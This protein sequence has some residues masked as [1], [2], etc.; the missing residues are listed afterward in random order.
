MNKE[1]KKLISSKTIQA[2][3]E[4]KHNATRIFLKDFSSIGLSYTLAM[5][6]VTRA[7]RFDSPDVAQ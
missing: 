3:N 1:N 4:S 5:S 7:T 6:E 2:N